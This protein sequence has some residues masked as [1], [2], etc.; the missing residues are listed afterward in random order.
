MTYAAGRVYNDA[1]SHVMATPTWLESYADAATRERLRPFRADVYRPEHLPL[2]SRGYDRRDLTEVEANLLI[3]KEWDAFGACDPSERSTALDLFGF[4]RQLVLSSFAIQQFYGQDLDLLYGGAQALNRAMGEFCG[5][6]DRL[7]AVG[8]L[9]LAQPD[10]DAPLI[11]DGLAQGCRAF[12]VPKDPLGRLSPT[13]SDFDPVWARL[14]QARTPFVL[15][16]GPDGRS[17]N[18]VFR[19]N[20]KEGTKPDVD[21]DGESILSKDFAALCHPAEVFLTA[22]IFDGVLERFPTLRGGVIELGA[23]WVVSWLQRIDMIQRLFRTTEPYLAELSQLPSDYVRRQLRFT[24]Y[25][26]EPLTWMMDEAGASLFMFSTDFPH[27]EG[28]RNP[29]K[30]FREHLDHRSRADQDLF[31]SDNFLT[32]VGADA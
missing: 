12:Q 10:L 28:G 4:D 18:P 23:S 20:G 31:Y 6:D 7:Y 2:E 26:S 30:R 19:V 25:S 15:H 27:P 32:M 3:A 9:P 29:L 24:P 22:L 17:F 21:G 16:V 13:H 14:E 8:F 1:D 11:D 5:H